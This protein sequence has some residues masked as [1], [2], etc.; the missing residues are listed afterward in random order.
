MRKSVRC[1]QQHR[2]TAVPHAEN[3]KE[4]HASNQRLEG[5][6]LSLLQILI[7]DKKAHLKLL[8]RCRDALGAG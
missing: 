1:M 7:G 6:R 8:K 2:Q 5:G 3:D 4:Q